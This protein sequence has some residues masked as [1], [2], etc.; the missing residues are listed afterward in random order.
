MFSFCKCVIKFE[1]INIFMFQLKL[2]FKYD[3]F[4]FRNGFT[5]LLVDLI[6]ADNYLSV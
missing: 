6:Y 1:L 3:R 4:R 2:K 5:E